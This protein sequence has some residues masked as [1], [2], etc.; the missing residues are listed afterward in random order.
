[1]VAGGVQLWQWEVVGGVKLGPH[2][3]VRVGWGVG[4]RRIST[5]FPAD[6]STG[7]EKLESGFTRRARRCEGR[8]QLGAQTVNWPQ[9]P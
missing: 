2:Q 7:C 3:S 5:F 8:L 9:V 4:G 6:V 1:M